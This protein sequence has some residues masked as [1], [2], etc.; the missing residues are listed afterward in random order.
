MDNTVTKINDK[1]GGWFIT[2]FPS[3]SVPKSTKDVVFKYKSYL[4]KCGNKLD[5]SNMIGSE[6]NYSVIKVYKGIFL[7]H[8]YDTHS[9]VLCI[10]VV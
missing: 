6:Y 4:V 1:Q 7:A 8:N 5:T 2:L 3:M 10:V 9:W